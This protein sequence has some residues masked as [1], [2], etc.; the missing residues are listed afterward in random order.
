EPVHP[1][2][3]HVHEHHVGAQ[4]VDPGHRLRAVRGVAD[5]GDVGL[6]VEQGGEPLPHHRLVVDDQHPEGHG[7]QPSRDRARV[8]PPT[9]TAAKTVKPPSAAGT[10]ENVPPTARTRA[11][12]PGIPLP[13]PTPGAMS[14]SGAAGPLST[15]RATD[16]GPSSSEGAAS[17][18]T[19]TRP[20]GA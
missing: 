12:I 15:S 19:T 6:G 10:A 1:G 17:R 14:A 18:V 4:R 5:H 16:G 7:G 9:G 11:D 13:P 2:H 20:P 8:T 3:A